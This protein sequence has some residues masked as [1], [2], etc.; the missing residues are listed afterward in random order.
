[1]CKTPLLIYFVIP[2]SSFHCETKTKRQRRLWKKI[3][4][5]RKG[6]YVLK[7]YPFF[8]DGIGFLCVCVFIFAAISI[9]ICGKIFSV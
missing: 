6:N 4:S 2:S 8:G 1:M 3:I 5:G 7:S 9:D